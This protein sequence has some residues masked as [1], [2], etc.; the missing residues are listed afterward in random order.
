MEHQINTHHREDERLAIAL[1]FCH[2]Y[3]NHPV[4]WLETFVDT[5]RFKGTCYKAANWH[6]LG[7]TSGRGKYNKTHKQLVSIKAM[8]GYPLVR[9]FRE[10]LCHG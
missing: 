7:K 10:K 9:D 3:Y 4:F 2:L 1:A 6:F 5:D 8:Y